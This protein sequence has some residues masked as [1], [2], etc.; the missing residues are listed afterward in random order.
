MKL[1]IASIG[2]DSSF[3]NKTLKTLGGAFGSF[4]ELSNRK[5]RKSN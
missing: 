3:V 2:D 1:Q 4:I 5:E